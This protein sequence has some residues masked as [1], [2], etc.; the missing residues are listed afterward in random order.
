MKIIKRIANA[1][2]GFEA[3]HGEKPKCIVVTSD[4]YIELKSSTYWNG[5]YQY[6]TLTT[7][8]FD[9]DVIVNDSIDGD[10]LLV[11]SSD[12]KESKWCFWIDNQLVKFYKVDIQHLLRYEINNA[13]INLRNTSYTSSYV[14]KMNATTYEK[15]KDC[16]PDDVD[17]YVVVD[18]SIGNM[19]F[20]M[21]GK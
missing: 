2:Y 16:L 14:L 6:E 15:M 17:Y 10:I 18:D 8:I 3:E 1:L 12:I 21:V 5:R 9:I 4:A 7:K 20:E 11:H 13:I 19:I